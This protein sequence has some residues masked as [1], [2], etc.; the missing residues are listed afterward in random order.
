MQ[1]PSEEIIQ[2]LKAKHGPIVEVELS[3]FEL[4]VVVAP[5]TSATCARYVD[6]GIISGDDA[7]DRLLARHVLWPE[8]KEVEAAKRRFARLGKRIADVL[9]EDAGLPLTSPA[10][11]SSDRL[12]ADTPPG[13]LARAGLTEAKAGELLAQHTDSALQVLV[14][15]AADGDTIFAGVLTS[16]G[17]V[18]LGLM[19]DAQAARKGYAAACV[20]ACRACV[21][22][23]S[24]SLDVVIERYPAIPML[25]LPA[26]MNELGGSAAA[27]RF[28]RR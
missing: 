28:R 21:V 14:V 17:E 22:W 16:P 5:F 19:R 4:C 6:E 9:C 3:S 2:A 7:S 15:T 25:L 26:E 10:K 23:S 24:T 12:A 27:K 1:R 20:S 13:V 18:E 11:T 8:P